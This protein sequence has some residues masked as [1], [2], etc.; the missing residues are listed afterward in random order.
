MRK[1]LYKAFNDGIID[2]FILKSHPNVIHTTNEA[3][4]EL[5]LSY[6]HSTADMIVKALAVNAPNFLKDPT[7]S[8]FFFDEICKPN[9][10]VEYYL[11]ETTG[12]FLLLDSDADP[13]WLIIKRKTD[14]QIYKEFAIDN[15]APQSIIAALDT[16]EKIPYFWHAND[17]FQTS[18][19]MWENSLHPAKKFGGDETYYYA[20]VKDLKSVNLNKDEVVSYNT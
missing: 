15:N 19:P 16:G 2:R 20:I 4:H 13:S 10:I 8:D 18:W 11:T 6:F 1:L 14:L 5:Q 12:S 3:I 17:Y 7:F 9:N